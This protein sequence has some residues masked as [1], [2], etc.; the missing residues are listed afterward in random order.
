MPLRE[1][2]IVQIGH[3]TGT[4]PAFGFL[5][6]GE[7]RRYRLTSLVVNRPATGRKLVELHCD[8]CHA[9]LLLRVR[10]LELSRTIRKRY[11]LTA[12]IGLAAA[13]VLIGSAIGLEEAGITVP[14]STALGKI[15]LVVSL[16]SL[17][18][19]G[20]GCYGWYR[21]E[22]LRL[23]SGTGGA[24]KEHR[25]LFGAEPHDAQAP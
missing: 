12:L 7:E 15:L 10:S 13:V 24:D 23:Y 20:I 25:L 4:S 5:W 19:L 16:L 3:L 2:S 8:T 18:V 9:E 17:V 6:I 11:M 22:G 21:E 14:L 1:Q